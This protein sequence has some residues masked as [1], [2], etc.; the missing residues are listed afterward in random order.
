MKEDV[1]GYS[2]S[3]YA[4]AQALLEDNAEHE[5][6]LG[7]A[8]SE[9]EFEWRKGGAMDKLTN[10][11]LKKA[12]RAAQKSSAMRL[13]T[14]APL[15]CVYDLVPADTPFGRL[16]YVLDAGRVP[17]EACGSASFL[18]KYGLDRVLVFGPPAPRVAPRQNLWSVYE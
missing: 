5:T 1:E 18:D 6:E 7:E 17:L 4:T 13:H 10:K 8:I 3:P 14:N 12:F 2:A 16:K 9:N 15:M 11:P